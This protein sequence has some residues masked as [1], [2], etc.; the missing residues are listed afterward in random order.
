MMPK[1]TVPFKHY[2][3]NDPL[4]FK[5]SQIK[6]MSIL[7]SSIDFSFTVYLNDKWG[8]HNLCVMAFLQETMKQTETTQY[9]QDLNG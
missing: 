6:L 2:E 7:E 5:I 8:L 4:K 1:Q 3:S 9:R